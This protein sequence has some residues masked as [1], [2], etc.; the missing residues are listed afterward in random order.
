[1]L[2][3]SNLTKKA[4][5]SSKADGF[6]TRHFS[7]DTLDYRQII[8][9][10]LPLLIDQAFLVCMNLVNTA[11]ISSSGVAAVS[12]VNMVD[13]VNIFLINVFIAVAT[14]GTIV[15]AQYKGRNNEEMVPKAVASS[16]AGVFLLAAG[17]SVV[18]LIFHGPILSILFGGSEP[19]VFENA[20]IYL[21]GSCISYSGIAVV[22]A[23]SGAL[24]GIGET[25]SSLVLTL[26]MNFIYL[27]LNAVLISGLHMGVLGMVISLNASRYISAACAI[28][29][30][31]RRNTSLGLHMRDLFSID[32]IM[33]RRIMSIGLPFAAEQMF[34]NGGKILTQTFIVGLGTYAMATNAISSSIVNLFQI[35]A[36]ALSLTIITVVGQCMGKRDTKQAKKVIKSFVI[37]ASVSFVVMSFLIL[38]FFDP[39][40]S[41]FKAPEVIIPD[42]FNIILITSVAQIP[43]WSISFLVP[44][45]LR[46]GGDS[47]YSSIMSM[48]SMWLFRVILGYV[49]GVILPF[50]VTGV[51]IAMC[52]EWGVRGVIFLSRFRG[53]KWYQHKVID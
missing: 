12:A 42:I 39:L 45:A 47:T 52:C 16:V 33:Q 18:I 43:L 31:V 8:S 21:I 26:T 37:L 1:M 15:V 44:A 53:K 17:I 34:F 10:I 6:L 2:Q 3:R 19:A 48:L 41:L 46:A 5:W 28:I 20:K 7:G 9:I 27:I 23:V 13:S 38:P 22:E 51:W 36:S 49:L 4:I 32:G 40:V 50:G 24:R 11:M 35:P 25:R 30:L 29:Y 14:G